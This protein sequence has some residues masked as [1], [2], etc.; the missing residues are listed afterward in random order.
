MGI[1]FD[2]AGRKDGENKKTEK[3]SEI[4]TQDIVTLPLVLLTILMHQH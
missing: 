3:T 1:D 4:Q 2:I